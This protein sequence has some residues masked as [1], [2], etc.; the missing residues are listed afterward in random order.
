MAFSFDMDDLRV[1][2]VWYKDPGIEEGGSVALWISPA[3][4]HFMHEIHFI[5]SGEADLKIGEWVYHLNCGDFCIV[6]P[7]TMHYPLSSVSPVGR[8]SMLFSLNRNGEK[9]VLYPCYAENLSRSEPVIAKGSP[10]L[11]FYVRNFSHHS[12]DVGRIAQYTRQSNWILLLTELNNCVRRNRQDGLPPDMGQ[13]RDYLELKLK[14][15][16][17]FNRNYMRSVTLDDLAREINYGKKQTA[18]LFEKIT[19]KTFNGC[20]L[21]WRMEIAR[22]LICSTDKSLE[23]IAAEVGYESYSGFFKAF[24]SFFGIIPTSLRE[25][26]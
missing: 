26:I 18:R 4:F 9:G 12:H 20:L 5:E 1:N 11:F 10:D 6:P 22:M 15:D 2:V 25:N 8:Y 3:H 17:F 24:R 21:A 7:N 14:I 19:G 16:A 23:E 13:D